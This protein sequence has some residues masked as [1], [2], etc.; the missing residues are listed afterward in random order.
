MAQNYSRLAKVE[1]NKS[2]KSAVIFGGLT[3]I[4]IIVAVIFGITLFSKF[5]N[6][7]SQ[8]SL[9]STSQNS[10][11]LLPPNLDVLPQ[12]TNQK[13]IIVK[14]T[15]TPNTRVRIFFKDA[16]DETTTDGSGTFALNVGLVSGANIIYAK[17]ID[18]NSNESAS[19]TSYTVNYS[20]KVPNLTVSVP[21][22]N[23]NFY[24]ST[25]QN[26]TIQG[27]TD[28]GN[29][30]TINEH[31]AILDNSGKFS[32]PFN[33]QNGDNQIKIISSD[34]AGNKKEIDLKVT[35]NH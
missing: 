27:S 29:T 25:E 6:L 19:S 3:I 34:Q 15:G 30:V 22:N 16:N 5:V 35:F 9:S 21:Q 10:V 28:Q 26:L 8:K 23:Q 32:F 17:T 1:E 2:I 4:I 13:S 33:L 7:F 18:D 11:T 24:G 31:I 20:D 14:G 12:N